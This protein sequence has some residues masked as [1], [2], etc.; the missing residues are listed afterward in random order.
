[1]LKLSTDRKVTPKAKQ[2]GSG[3]WVPEIP[4][5]F[6]LPAHISCPGKTD[7]CSNIC[8]AFNLER[9]YTNVAKLLKHNWDTLQGKSREEMYVYLAIMLDE[10]IKKHRR[11]EKLRGESY[12][13]VFRIHWDGDF[14]SLEYAEAWALAMLDHPEVQFW[15]YTRSFDFVPALA[16]VPNLSLYLSVDQENYAEAV[17]VY[18][19][20]PQVR[21]AAL[22]KTF[23]EANVFMQ[24]IKA[25]N[26]PKCPE[27]T[28]TY[29]LVGEEGMGACVECMMC[30][31]GTN[32][33]L[34]SIS[35]K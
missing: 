19:D 15:A 28:G 26:A 29:P 9:V 34:F 4:N 20:Y 11:V 23:E 2:D 30:I 35:K 13:L 10:Y 18:Y 8:Y 5:A 24:H 12:P 1:M 6:G 31:N 3:R 16:E 22:D 14:F 21:I 7:V 25:K 27:Q 17:Q 33:V 32:D